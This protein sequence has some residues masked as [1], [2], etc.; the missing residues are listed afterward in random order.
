MNKNYNRSQMCAEEWDE[1]QYD[2]QM[3]YNDKKNEEDFPFV[4]LKVYVLEVR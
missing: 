3:Q 1:C 2:K 4:V